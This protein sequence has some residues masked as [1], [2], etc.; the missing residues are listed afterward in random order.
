MIATNP[1]AFLHPDI[2]DNSSFDIIGDV[3]G[4]YD[5]VCNLLE[6]LDYKIDKQNILTDKKAV[7][8]PNKRIPLFLGD[9]IDRGPKSPE[10]L[11]LAMNMV[12][13]G[14]GMCILGNHELK[15]LRYLSG[16][17]VQLLH[18][19]DLTIKQLQKYP[20]RFHEEVK[21][22]IRTLPWYLMLNERKL[23]VAH[24]GLKENLQGRHSQEA[25][26][27]A[28]FGDTTGKVDEYGFPIRRDWTKSYKGLTSVVYGHMSIFDAQWINNTI[29]IDTSC[30]FGGKLTAL[31]YPEN[32]LVSVFANDIYANYM[33][34]HLSSTPENK[35]LE[36]NL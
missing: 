14:S 25:Y 8:H 32:E 12:K 33:H 36:A 17:K 1:N 24:A 9:L 7:T 31:R 27:F 11:A 28:L 19:L 34:T 35:S 21:E 22:F 30:V 3:H 20:P 4:C 15:L 6:K 29:C 5:E 10:V 26:Y 13:T 2:K 16:K 23:V 18:G